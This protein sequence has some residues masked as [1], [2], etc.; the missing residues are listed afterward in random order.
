MAV[1]IISSNDSK[2]TLNFSP[3]FFNFSEII[4]TFAQNCSK[5]FSKF[6]KIYFETSFKMLFFVF[7]SKFAQTSNLSKIQIV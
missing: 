2:I 3:N 4:K 7:P 5:I 1:K 6:P